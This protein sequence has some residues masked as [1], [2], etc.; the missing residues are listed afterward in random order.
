[1]ATSSS[2]FHLT[3]RIIQS[4]VFIDEIIEV[5]ISSSNNNNNANTLQLFN[6][7]LGKYE[8]IISS[9]EKDINTLDRTAL[10]K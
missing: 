5:S 2:M 8:R 6:K 7:A 3:E 4:H 10:N 9:L 1:M